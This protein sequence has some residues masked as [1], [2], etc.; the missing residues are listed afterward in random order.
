MLETN[1]SQRE[2]LALRK[3][4]GETLASGLGLVSISIRIVVQDRATSR[5]LKARNHTLLHI[6]RVIIAVRWVDNVQIYNVLRNPVEFALDDIT[7]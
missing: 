2:A 3:A 4:Y 6:R 5:S 7:G 1:H